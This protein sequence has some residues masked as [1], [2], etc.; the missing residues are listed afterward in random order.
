MDR[1]LVYLKQTLSLQSLKLLVKEEMWTNAAILPE[2]K[3]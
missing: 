2:M 1:D 3:K